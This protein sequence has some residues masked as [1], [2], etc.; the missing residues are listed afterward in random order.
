MARYHQGTFVPKNPRKFE[1]MNGKITFR[2][3]W[4]LKCME[5]F[6]QNPSI[7]KVLSE[8]IAIPYFNPVKRRVANY[9]PDFYLEY[10]DKTGAKKKVLIEVKPMAQVVEQHNE[11]TYAKLT[12]AVNIAKWEAAVKWCNSRSVEF[13]ILTEKQ[14]FGK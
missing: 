10:T 4:E 11:T 12:R 8:C 13:Q 9:Y 1:G 7:T 14:I 2:S 6:D 5:F 3:S